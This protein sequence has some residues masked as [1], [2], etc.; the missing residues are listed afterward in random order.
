MQY[1]VFVAA[2]GLEYPHTLAAFVVMV[3][4]HA[5]DGFG[6]LLEKSFGVFKNYP[7]H[8]IRFAVG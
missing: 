8:G 6:A 3:A 4:A 1:V 7:A 2:C 5:I